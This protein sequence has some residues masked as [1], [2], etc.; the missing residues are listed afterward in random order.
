VWAAHAARSSGGDDIVLSRVHSGTLIGI[1]AHPIEVEIDVYHGLPSIAVVGLPDNA[2]KESTAR[3]KFA[4]VNSGYPFPARRIT[5]NLAPADLK[6]EGSGFDLP[7]ALGI[8][9]ALN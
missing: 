5:V 1:D 3:V 4:I 2:V 7:I 8:L 9:A 6:K